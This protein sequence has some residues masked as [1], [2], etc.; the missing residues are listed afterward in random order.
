MKQRL[1]AD[2]ELWRPSAVPEQSRVKW[3]NGPT[4]R[5]TLLRISRM[6][7]RGGVQ[8][9]AVETSEVNMILE[10]LRWRW[11]TLAAFAIAYNYLRLL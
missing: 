4:R 9:Q 8:C 10:S 2:L 5:T 1:E 6:A 11:A 7:G 3:T